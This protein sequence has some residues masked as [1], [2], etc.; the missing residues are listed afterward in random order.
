M[1]MQT[2][3]KALIE[4]LKD[5]E[6]LEEFNEKRDAIC[7]VVEALGKVGSEKSEEAL[8]HLDENIK[9]ECKDKFGKAL[10]QIRFRIS[11]GGNNIE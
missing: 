6:A 4:A 9:Q 8:K 2:I 3:E 7:S 1:E 10:E 5:F 11:V